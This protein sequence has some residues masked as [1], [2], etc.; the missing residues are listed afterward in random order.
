[1]KL[2]YRKIFC[3]LFFCFCFNSVQLHALVVNRTDQD[4]SDEEELVFENRSIIKCGPSPHETILTLFD[5]RILL[6]ISNVLLDTKVP[7]QTDWI[8]LDEPPIVS[9]KNLN[10]IPEDIARVVFLCLNWEDL[11]IGNLF[12]I[13]K[14]ERHDVLLKIKQEVPW[15]VY[16]KDVQEKMKHFSDQYLGKMIYIV[17]KAKY[18]QP[19]RGDLMTNPALKSIKFAWLF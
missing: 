9:D 13:S 10:D 11:K 1:M 3:L 14:K 4:P 2:F 5:V 12:A 7:L 19:I 8:G 17:L 6:A 15:N 16:S 18:S